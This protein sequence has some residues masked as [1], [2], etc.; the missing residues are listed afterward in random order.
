MIAALCTRGEV[1]LSLSTVNTGS[2]QICLF[3]KW[4][5]IKLKKQDPDWQ[6]KTVLQLDGASYH[7]S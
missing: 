5:M 6:A 2:E 1:F 3:L 7:K 4:L